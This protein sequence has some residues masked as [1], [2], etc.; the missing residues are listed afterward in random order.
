[1][2]LEQFILENSEPNEIWKDIPNFED[3]YM[4]ST[5]GRVIAKEKYVNN[6]H[7]NV[8]KPIRF[9]KIHVDDNRK[10]ITLSRNGKDKRFSLSLLMASIFLP[11]PNNDYVLKFKD[12]NTLNCIIDNLIWV[13]KITRRLEFKIEPIEGEVWKEIPEYEGLYAISNKG[14]IKSLER[15]TIATNRIIHQ[16]E[17]LLTPSPNATG[18]LHIHLSKD[19]I[20]KSFFIHRLVAMCFIDNPNNYP[21][22][23]H[24]DTNKNNNSVENLRWVTPSLNMQNDLTRKH[25]SQAG[26]SKYNQNAACIPIVQLK[27]GILIETYPSTAEAVRRGNFERTC[28]SACLNGHQRKHKGFTWM[29]LSEYNKLT[30]ETITTQSEITKSIE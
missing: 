22:I 26:K 10:K 20:R 19:K 17:K 8:L 18:Y 25:L 15:D 13:K 11:K 30:P 7:Q 5:H 9:L 4:I 24:I 21:H 2:T 29:Y 14:R 6:G 28:I 12:D 3:L 16:S 27:D 1:M 23:D